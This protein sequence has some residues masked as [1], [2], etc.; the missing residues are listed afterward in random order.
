MID[1][2]MQDLI[3]S[4]DEEKINSLEQICESY[5]DPRIQANIDIEK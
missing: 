1:K 5:F 4:S 3:T 2:A